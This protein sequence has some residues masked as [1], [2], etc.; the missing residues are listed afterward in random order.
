MTLPEQ[1]AAPTKLPRPP[2]PANP[3][4]PP[5]LVARMWQRSAS[6]AGVAVRLACLISFAAALWTHSIFG[7]WIALALG[8]GCLAALN[9]L[10]FILPS[11][12][13]A[14]S[15]AARASY[16]ERIWMNRLAVP[17]PPDDVRPAIALSA[18]SMAGAAVLLTGAWMN[19]VLLTASGCAVYLAARLVFLDRMAALYTRMQSA[20]PLYR[21]WALRP[22]NDNSFRR[23]VSGL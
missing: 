20:H 1:S 15:W 3:R 19:S 16:G 13:R 11:T 21:S 14:E 18:A 17:V 6:A 10:V 23:R 12:R 2:T 8:I 9:G 4:T 7:I 5:P 22:D